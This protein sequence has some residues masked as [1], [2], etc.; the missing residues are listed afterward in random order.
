M[1][2]LEDKIICENCC[3]F[4]EETNACHLYTQYDRTIEKN[5]SGYKVYKITDPKNR[6]SKFKLGAFDVMLKPDCFD[7][8]G[9]PLIVDFSDVPGLKAKLEKEE[10]TKSKGCY[11]ATAVYGSYDA[12]EVL[13]LRKFRDE[14]LQNNF[15]G[16][17]FVKI[18]YAI[19]PSIA[20]RLKSAKRLNRF[21]KER[22][23]TFVEYIRNKFNFE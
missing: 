12:P 1:N 6:C 4:E 16:R 23:D 5:G 14:I 15:F 13:T 17:L 3:F 21:V 22:L 7:E 20:K 18:Y 19:S 8:E 10:N 2:N 11:I 9:N